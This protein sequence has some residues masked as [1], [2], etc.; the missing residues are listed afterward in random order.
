METITKARYWM[1]RQRIEGK[2]VKCNVM[3]MWS[4]R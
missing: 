3:S 2:W 1:Q 4:L